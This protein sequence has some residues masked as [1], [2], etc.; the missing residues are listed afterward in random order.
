MGDGYFVDMKCTM[1]F[2]VQWDCQLVEELQ[3]IEIEHYHGPKFRRRWR[4]RTRMSN[5]G[6]IKP[7]TIFF[8]R[9]AGQ[10][11]TENWE[12]AFKLDYFL[13]LRTF[14]VHVF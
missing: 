9:Q 13:L 3:L 7:F 1:S 12:D 10:R 11:M 8:G 6:Y 2:S 5:R 14:D 4:R